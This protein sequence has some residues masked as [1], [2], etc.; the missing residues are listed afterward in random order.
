MLT[1]AKKLIPKT[2]KDLDVSGELAS[3]VVNFYYTELRKK[4]EGLNDSRIR[5][6]ALG[7][8]YVSRKKLEKSIGTITH[9]IQ[10]EKPQDFRGI[11]IRNDL[12]NRLKVQKK[13]LRKINIEMAEYNERKKDLG[14]S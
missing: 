5:V 1:K 13:L 9:I 12:M 4:M 8:F 7:V 10:T 14:R 11:S 3:D 2:A 6:P